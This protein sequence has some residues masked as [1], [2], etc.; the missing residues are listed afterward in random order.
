M[1]KIVAFL[2][3]KNI[4]S[5]KTIGDID[6]LAKDI[7]NMYVPSKRTIESSELS[8]KE[9]EEEKN[10]LLEARKNILPW[11]TLWNTFIRL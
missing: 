4:R 5:Q 8:E 9:K 1:D 3:G 11:C 10:V 6:I 7:N 2:K